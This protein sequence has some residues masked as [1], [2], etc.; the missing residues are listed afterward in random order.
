MPDVENPE[1]FKKL[2]YMVTLNNKIVEIGAMD[3]PSPI[4]NIMR[5]PYVERLI[6]EVFQVRG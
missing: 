4:K 2:D 6:A 5:A 3:L 1:F